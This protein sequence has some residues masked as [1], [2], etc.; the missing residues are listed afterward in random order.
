M[1][2]YEVEDAKSIKKREEALRIRAKVPSLFLVCSAN[3]D[4]NLDENSVN[5]EPRFL[6]IPFSSFFSKTIDFSLQQ[7]L[8]QRLV[9]SLEL[10]ETFVRGT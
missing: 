9:P 8:F 2:V 4:T 1:I 3:P 10:E 5:I 6:L 7:P